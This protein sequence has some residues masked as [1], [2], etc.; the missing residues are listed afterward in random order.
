MY[1]LPIAF[2]DG[3][4]TISGAVFWV[5]DGNPEM[6][7]RCPDKPPVVAAHMAQPNQEVIGEYVFTSCPSFHVLV[8]EGLGHRTEGRAKETYAWIM[9]SVTVS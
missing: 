6:H 2:P 1:C 7:R 8:V 3:K 5:K 9:C 4:M